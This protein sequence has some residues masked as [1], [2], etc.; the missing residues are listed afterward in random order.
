MVVEVVDVVVEVV[1]V[2][3]DVDGAVVTGVVVDV[4]IVVEVD[5]A[6]ALDDVETESVDSPP[7]LLQPTT[8][9]A[10]AIRGARRSGFTSG[11]LARDIPIT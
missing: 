4:T 8:A 7:S 3:V 9:S 2:V 11:S 10:R 5:V 1:D 6:E